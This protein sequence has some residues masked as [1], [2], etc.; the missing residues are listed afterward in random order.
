[1]LR[2]GGP[3][4]DDSSATQAAHP[5][6]L[7]HLGARPAEGF[8]GWNHV[9]LPG[10]RRI[11]AGKFIGLCGIGIYLKY[12]SFADFCWIVHGMICSKTV[13]NFGC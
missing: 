11:F 2:Q 5:R 8:D 9:D 10:F 4:C 3:T 12:V 13:G 1:M 7:R 6:R